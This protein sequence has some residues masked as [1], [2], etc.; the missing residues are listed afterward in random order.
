MGQQ[1]NDNGV[2]TDTTSREYTYTQPGQLIE[3]LINA[4]ID[5]YTTMPRPGR[6]RAVRSVPS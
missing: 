2:Y 5:L 6:P 3:S 1:P 4:D